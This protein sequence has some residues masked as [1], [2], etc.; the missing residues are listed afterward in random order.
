[1]RW[2]LL[3]WRSDPV[4][5]E[6]GLD[7]G[8]LTWHHMMHT[9]WTVCLLQVW[10]GNKEE[11]RKK[12]KGRKGGG[13]ARERTSVVMVMYLYFAPLLFVFPVARWKFGM[14]NCFQHFSF[15]QF[16][17]SSGKLLSMFKV[18]SVIAVFVCLLIVFVSLFV[19]SFTCGW[20]MGCRFLFVVDKLQD[21]L[22]CVCR[23]GEQG[24]PPYMVSEGDRPHHWKLAPRLQRQ[25]LGL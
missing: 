23:S 11:E 25:V 21:F 2:R 17:A 22:S 24:V 15:L 1:M 6:G 20:F 14:L 16:L 9:T 4:S 7:F 13:E 3:V 5:L 18:L 8:C 19:C 10:K 12:K